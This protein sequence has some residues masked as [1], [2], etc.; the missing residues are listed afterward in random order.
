MNDR[1]EIE[2]EKAIS[3][4]RNPY[5]ERAIGSR[6]IAPCTVIPNAIVYE[7]VELT[8]SELPS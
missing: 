5:P 8:T 3:I 7:P 4:R 1:S 2:A 6:L